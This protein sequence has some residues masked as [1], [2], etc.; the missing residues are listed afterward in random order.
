MINIKA[1]VATYFAKIDASNTDNVKKVQDISAEFDKFQA[2]FVNPAQEVDGKLY[3]FDVKIQS[4]EQ[5]RESQFAILK[6]T[7]QK[8]IAA[9]DS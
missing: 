1:M 7:I 3:A 9:L 4:S 5:M 6:D 8:I 2:T